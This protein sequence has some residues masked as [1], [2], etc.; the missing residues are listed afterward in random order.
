MTIRG[1]KQ[2]KEFI[3]RLCNGIRREGD[4]CDYLIQ[5]HS[6]D[7]CDKQSIEKTVRYH[8]S[9]LEGEE[10]I[11]IKDNGRILDLQR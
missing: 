6:N 10:M 9:K 1:N 5:Y 3:Y 4:I 8:I 2:V 7:Y 11:Y